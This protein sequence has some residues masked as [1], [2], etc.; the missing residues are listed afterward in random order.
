MKNT[1]LNYLIIGILTYYLIK[2][3]LFLFMWQTLVHIEVKGKARIAKQ[4][5]EREEAI[6]RRR[7]IRENTKS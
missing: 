3:V 1:A 6:I 4:K 2:G 5:E 7:E